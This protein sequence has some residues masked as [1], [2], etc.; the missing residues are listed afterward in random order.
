MPA[1]PQLGVSQ[2]A[3]QAD[4]GPLDAL[5][6][7][8]APERLRAFVVG[9]CRVLEM[10]AQGAPLGETLDELVRVLEGQAEGMLCTVLLLSEDGRRVR[11]GAAPSLPAAYR[12][13]IE[14]Q[15][16]GPRAG[17]CGTAAFLRQ[18]VIVTDIGADPLWAGY[19]AAALAAGLHACWSTPILSRRSE[20]L[21]TFAIYY[22]APK[23]PEPLHR[24]LIALATHL[25]GVAIE[26]TLA[27]RER[28]RLMTELDIDRQALAN[29]ARHKDQFMAML[30]HELRNP[31]AAISSAVA[32]ARGRLA[33][34]QEVGGPLGILERQVANCARL[35]DDLLDV[36]RFSRGMVQVHREPVRLQDAVAGAVEAQRGLAER[37]GHQLTVTLP[38]P[39]V[40][41]EGTRPGSSRWSRTCSTTRSSTAPT[42]ATS[43]SRWRTRRARPCCACATTAPA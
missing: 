22:R 1:G 35:L 6:A 32:V 17:S 33:R 23:G 37:H 4:E 41:V 12:E 24:H 27:D 30:A 19:R 38:E 25:A 14:N 34:G 18:Q 31:L 42:A 20:V 43:S 29:E 8:Q 16:I 40:V 21:G 11:H 36:A 10:I 2:A 3:V 7:L 39:A 26:R 15:P 28:Q 9:Q 13:A 5:F